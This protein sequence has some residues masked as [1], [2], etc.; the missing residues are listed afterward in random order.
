MIFLFKILFFEDECDFI[1]NLLGN[2]ISY[3]CCNLT[4]ISCSDNYVVKM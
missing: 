4:G 2:D 1:N 3:N